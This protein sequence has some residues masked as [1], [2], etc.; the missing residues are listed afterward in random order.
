[1]SW[2]SKHITGGVRRL[3]EHTIE[4]A[5]DVLGMDWAE[6]L[7]TQQKRMEQENERI[8]QQNIITAKRNKIAMNNRKFIE[9]LSF[10]QNANTKS[11]FNNKNTGMNNSTGKKKFNNSNTSMNNKND[12]LQG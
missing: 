2:W 11:N 12:K 8:R 10:I 3:K 1:M 4:T 6:D 7:R 5:D 9:G